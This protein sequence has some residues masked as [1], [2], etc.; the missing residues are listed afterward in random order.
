MNQN[1]LEA[2]KAHVAEIQEV[3]K[4]N[5]SFVVAEYRG[6]NDFIQEIFS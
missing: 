6:L 4:N 2:K 5:K 1:V 3:I